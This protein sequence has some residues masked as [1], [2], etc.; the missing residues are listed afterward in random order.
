MSYTGPTFITIKEAA[1]MLGL[2]PD[3]VHHG[4]AGTDKLTRVR[5]GRSVRMIRQEVDAH[6]QKQLKASQ[7]NSVN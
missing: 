6:I 5:F 1:N 4:K 2:S 3:T 7:R